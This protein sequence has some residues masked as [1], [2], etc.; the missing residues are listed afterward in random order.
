MNF[1]PNWLK[2][3]FS[4]KLGLFFLASL[5]WFLVVTERNFESVLNIP[6]KVEGLSEDKCLLKPVADIAKVKVKARGKSLLQLRLISKSFL[7]LDLSN[8][9]G[10]ESVKLGTEH[11][12]MPRGLEVTPV[13]IIH[14]D[15][16]YIELDDLAEYEMPIRPQI[17]TVPSPGY[18]VTGHIELEPST[19][20]VRGPKSLLANYKAIESVPDAM[21][22]IKRNTTI[23]LDLMLPEVFGISVVPD[24]VNALIRIERLGERTI[25]GVPIKVKNA[26]P[27]REITLQPSSVDIKITGGVSVIAELTLDDLT[28]SVDFNRYRPDRGNG[29]KVIIT[30]SKPIDIVRS[31]PEDVFFIVRRL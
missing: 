1:A 29:V 20:T 24:K 16:I 5:L 2:S 12:V 31:E 22:D 3:N 21:K 6:I 10:K 19:V 13:D 28:A 26:P 23:L 15:S 11:V 7:R 30:S 17:K 27:N 14:P 4:V 8:I 9:E 18:T 25:I